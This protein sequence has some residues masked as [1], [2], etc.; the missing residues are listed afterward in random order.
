MERRGLS[1]PCPHWLRRT[2]HRQSLLWGGSEDA[3]AA[4]S[5][6]GAPVWVKSLL[7]RSG[8]GVRMTP[9]WM[10]SKGCQRKKRRWERGSVPSQGCPGYGHREK[11]WYSLAVSLF[12][13]ALFCASLHRCGDAPV[14]AV[15]VSSPLPFDDRHTRPAFRWKHTQIHRRRQ[16]KK[17]PAW[18]WCQCRFPFD[19]LGHTPNLNFLSNVKQSPLCCCPMMG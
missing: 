14:P 11:A 13:G 8:P 17:S 3:S 6:W 2:P 19:A 18:L 12:R 10:E 4:F 1:E 9:H 16:W 7:R 5:L 15:L